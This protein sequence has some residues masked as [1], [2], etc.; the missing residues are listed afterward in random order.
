M[1]FKLFK[2]FQNIFWQNTSGWLLLKFICDFLEVFHWETAYF[3]YKFQNFNLEIQWKTIFHRSFSSIL[4][5]NENWL[6]EGIHLL[7][8]RENVL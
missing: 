4:Y 7:K 5:K 3:M 2:A 8:I 1:F 6:F